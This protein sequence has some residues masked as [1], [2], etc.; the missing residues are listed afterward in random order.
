VRLEP[1]PSLRACTRLSHAAYL[2]A[3]LRTV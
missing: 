3:D 1:A 2:F